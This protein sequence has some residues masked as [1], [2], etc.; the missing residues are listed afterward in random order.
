MA[1]TEF[2]IAD[3]VNLIERA[4][5]SD[6]PEAASRIMPWRQ[7]GEVKDK[8]AQELRDLGFLVPPAHPHCRSTLLPLF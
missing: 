5:F 6:D 3:A 2:W 8:N 1:G 7:A 4:A